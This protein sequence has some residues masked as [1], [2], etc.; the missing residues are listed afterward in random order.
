MAVLSRGGECIPLHFARSVPH[1]GASVAGFSRGRP[2][3]CTWLFFVL[4]LLL[5]VSAR[6]SEAPPA[7]EYQLKAALL[8]NFAKFVEWPPSRFLTGQSAIQLCVLGQDPFGHD[9]EH[10]IHNETIGGRSLSVVRVPRILEPEAC[11]I[12]FISASEKERFG[13]VLRALK[14][15]A[16]LTVG[17]VEGF[18]R[19]GGIANFMREGNRVRF[20]VNVEAA[21]RAGL[22]ISSKLLKLAKIVHDKGKP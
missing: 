16:V 6:G 5:A 14:N 13:S 11:H 19:S 21:E 8:Y 10:I 18:A 15:H 9:L 7:T 2:G 17:D 1:E 20:E 12:L 22:K 4:W 3:R